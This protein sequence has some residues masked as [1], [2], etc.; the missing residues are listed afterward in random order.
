MESP[1]TAALYRLLTYC[2]DIRQFQGMA[3]A[4]I[5]AG[6]RAQVL[7][8]CFLAPQCC[9]KKRPADDLI[10]NNFMK[11][12]N[13]IKIRPQ[14]DFDVVNNTESGLPQEPAAGLVFQKSLT[15]SGN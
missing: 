5:S 13:Y 7:I 11:S 2:Y 4:R 3:A 6:R 8:S 9:K 12:D 14:P 1:L 15:T 10:H